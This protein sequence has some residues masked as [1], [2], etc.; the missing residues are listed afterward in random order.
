MNYAT[1]WKQLLL[2]NQATADEMRN[3]RTSMAYAATPESRLY[4]AA[5]LRKG[6]FLVKITGQFAPVLVHSVSFANGTDKEIGYGKVKGFF[7]AVSEKTLFHCLT[8][9]ALFF[10]SSQCLDSHCRT[11]SKPNPSKPST[12]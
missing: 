3:I 4:L 10:R 6:A 7:S 2:S 11:S 9:S 5:T 1:T 8:T 12:P